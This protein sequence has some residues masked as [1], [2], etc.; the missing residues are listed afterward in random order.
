[1]MK[2]SFCVAQ[3]LLTQWH[4]EGVYKIGVYLDNLCDQEYFQKDL[5][6]NPETHHDRLNAIRD[7]VNERF[8]VG[9]MQ[10][11]RAMQVPSLTDVIA[12]AWKPDGVR[13]SVETDTK[14]KGTG[15]K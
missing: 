8:G 7:A 10:T 14:R 2:Q 11:A 6:A 12:P 9:S 4:G 3:Q 13:N 15:R 1:M 5:F